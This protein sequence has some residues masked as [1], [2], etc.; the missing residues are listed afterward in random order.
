MKDKMISIGIEKAIELAGSGWWKDKTPEEICNVQLFTSELCMD[1]GDFHMALEKCL[2]RPVWTHEL[3]M[4]YDGLC[5]EFL[6]QQ[7]PPTFD[8]IVGLLDKNKTVVV[9]A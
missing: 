3:G 7:D 8:E 4:N 1:F 2:R 5:K 9:V 6:K